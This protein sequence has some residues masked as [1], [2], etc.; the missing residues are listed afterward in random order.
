MRG[1][2]KQKILEDILSLF[3]GWKSRLVIAVFGATIS[4]PKNAGD[5]AEA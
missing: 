4:C 5:K 1:T 3:K 2:I